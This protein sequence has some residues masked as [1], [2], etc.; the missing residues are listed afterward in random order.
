M[1]STRF[2]IVTSLSGLAALVILLQVI[3]GYKEGNDE[4]Q[5]Q[6]LDATLQQGALYDT[7]L[8][9]IAQRVAQVAQQTQDQQLKDLLERQ[10]F[11]IRPSSASGAPAAPENSTTR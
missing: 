8:L 6:Q 4:R 5:L 7:H 11:Q 9:Q 2:I 1:S 3:F 10:H